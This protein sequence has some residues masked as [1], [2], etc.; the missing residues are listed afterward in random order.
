MPTT[1]IASSADTGIAMAVGGIIA[2]IALS[3]VFYAIGRGE[4]REREQAAADRA[5]ATE[6]EADGAAATEREA[7]GAAATEGDAPPA[8]Q[9]PPPHPRLPRRPRRRR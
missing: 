1:I 3:A 5:A 8:H 2:V 9:P 4:D 6:S 7:D